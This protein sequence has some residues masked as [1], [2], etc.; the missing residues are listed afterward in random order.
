MRAANFFITFRF[1]KP[2]YILY[3]VNFLQ[4]TANGLQVRYIM[5]LQKD[6][7]L[8]YAILRFYVESLHINVQ[9]TR[10]DLRDLM[11]DAQVINTFHVYCGWEE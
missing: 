2:L 9:L 4:I 3:L 5:N 6:F 1:S 11:H 7:T 10:K 8:E